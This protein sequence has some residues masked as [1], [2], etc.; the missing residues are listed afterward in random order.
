[1]RKNGR[2][3]CQSYGGFSR[4]IRRGGFFSDVIQDRQIC[5]IFSKLLSAMAAQGSL[6]SGYWLVE[7]Y[8][9][10]YRPGSNARWLLWASQGPAGDA[11][12]ETPEI[13]CRAAVILIK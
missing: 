11:L 7:A 5:T 2:L 10:S 6:V 8:F 1:M 13:S 3:K 4:F 9:L 12:M